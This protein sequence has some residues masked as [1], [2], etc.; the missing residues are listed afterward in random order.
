M[1]H[2]P[3]DS[4]LLSTLLSKEKDYSK[5][6]DTLLDASNASL[7]SVVAYASASPP[8]HS[9][10]LLNIVEFLARIDDATRNQYARGVEEW[11]RSMEELKELEEQVA[12]VV[13]DREIL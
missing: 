5:Q 12:R 7:N 6:L 2:R 10:L 13:R 3:P 4:R 8:A 1:V 11:R 9:S